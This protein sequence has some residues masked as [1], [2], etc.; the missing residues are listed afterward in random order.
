LI[1]HGPGPHICFVIP[2][3]VS[4]IISRSD[5]AFAAIQEKLFHAKREAVSGERHAVSAKRLALCAL[6]SMRRCEIC[7]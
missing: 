1:L 6:L 5:A 2:E 4:I 7:Y 3:T